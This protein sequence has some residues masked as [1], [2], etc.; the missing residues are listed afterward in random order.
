MNKLV[1]FVFLCV[2][3]TSANAVWLNSTGK[4][5]GIITYAGKETILIN[6]S[7]SGAD[8]EECLN[9][10]TFAISSSISPEARARMYSMLL[11]AQ[12]TGR[13]VTVSYND[14]GSCEP[15]DSNSSVY[16]KI[17]RLQ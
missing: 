1:T 17:V 4:I 6:I 16:R 2:L 3:S 15:W 13:N 10:N 12:A 7:A 8:V 9:K 14:V 5:T 11:S